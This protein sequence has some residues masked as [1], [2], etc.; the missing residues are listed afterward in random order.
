MITGFI[1]TAAVDVVGVFDS[2]F[3]QRFGDARPMKASV[4]EISKA[5]AHPIESGATITD[6]RIILP[7]EIELTMMLAGAAYR[8]TYGRIRE[9]FQK[10]EILTMQTKAGSYSNMLIVEMP[11]DENPDAFGTLTLTLKLKEVLIVTARYEKLPP[12]KVKNKTH[13]STVQRGEQ[14]GQPT[15]KKSSTLHDIFF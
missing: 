12:S 7:V 15:K 10:G 13:A 1:P 14:F 9:M 4:K 6:H 5:M 8:D 3:Q 2:S 11:H